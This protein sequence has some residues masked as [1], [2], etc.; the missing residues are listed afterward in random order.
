[1]VYIPA[2]E[3]FMGSDPDDET[4]RPWEKPREQ[5]QHP[6]FL[7]AFYIDTHEV[8]NAE[9]A[10]FRPDHQR[11]PT[12]ACAE[13]P[14]TQV[15]WFEARDYCAAQRPPK[16]LPT[17]AEWEKAAKGGAE[18]RPEPLD[19]YAW[20]AKNVRT[21]R[22]PEGNV[23]GAEPVG[24]LLPNGYG[25]HDMLG[26]AREWTGDWFGDDYYRQRVRDNPK[27][28]AEGRNRVERGGSFINGPR[29]VTA[30]IRFN[31][32]PSLR[33]FFLG[34]RCARDP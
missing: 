15:T 27:G 34:F 10:R 29:D 14:V 18:R 7:D 16:R 30:T 5:P 19:A 6:V 25:V 2:G 12:S 9:F 1:M 21:V 11:H 28:P 23:Y 20:H 24:R 32:P 13:C 22:L 3:F 17:E 26:N 4:V 33:L 8:T 31:H